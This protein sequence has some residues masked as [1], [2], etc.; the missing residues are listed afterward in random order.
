MATGSSSFFFNNFRSSREQDLLESLIIESISIYGED[1]YYIPRTLVNT[2]RLYGAD[3]QSVYNQA[4]NICMYIDSIDGFGGNGSFMSKIAGLEIKDQIDFTVAQ[5]I[6]N[7]NVANS[8]GAIRPNEG[9][10]IYFPLNNKCFQVVFVDKF[11]MFYQLGKVYTWKMTCQLFEY[12]N[13]IFN[14]GIPDIDIIQNLFDMNIYDWAILDQN[15]NF[16][17]NENGDFLQIQGAATAQLVAADDDQEIHNEANT[18]IDWTIIDPFSEGY[19]GEGDV[20]TL[21]PN[22]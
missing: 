12:S 10:L 14:T 2:D 5:R 11:E 15:G 16:L 9:D 4:F 18:V 1:V 6:F 3:D 17:I 20:Q 21:L 7:E 22:S 8:T 19:I 13:E